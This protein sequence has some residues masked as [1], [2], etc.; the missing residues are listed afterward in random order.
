MSNQSCKRRAQ[1]IGFTQVKPF[2]HTSRTKDGWRAKAYRSIASL[3]RMLARPLFFGKKFIVHVS[4]TRLLCALLI[5]EHAVGFFVT[6]V[7]THVIVV[8]M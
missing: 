4:H 6:G 5:R 8:G 7:M 2:Y 3:A 1:A